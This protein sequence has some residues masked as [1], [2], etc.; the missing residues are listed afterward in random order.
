MAIEVVLKLFQKACSGCLKVEADSTNNIK[1][2]QHSSDPR[3]FA[4]IVKE[5]KMMMSSLNELIKHEEEN[6]IKGI[7]RQKLE[8]WH[9]IF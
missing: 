4:S 3:R 9:S 2:T 7:P 5:L 6:E 8:L 1:L